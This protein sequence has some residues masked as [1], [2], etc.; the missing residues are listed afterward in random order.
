VGIHDNFFELGGSSLL[1]IRL[2]PEVEKQLG[3]KMA[4]TSIFEGPTIQSFAKLM[5]P[6]CDDAA[7]VGAA[8]G[9][10]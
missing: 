2:M 8:K 5:S 10:V 3:V 7:A 6:A 9:D 1:A 4:T